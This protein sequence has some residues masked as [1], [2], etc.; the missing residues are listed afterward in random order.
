M[1]FIHPAPNCYSE[2]KPDNTGKIVVLSLV[3]S[4]KRGQAQAQAQAQR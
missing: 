3:V 4:T 1:L 2:S